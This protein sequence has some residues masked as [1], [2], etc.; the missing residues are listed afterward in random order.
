M[1]MAAIWEAVEENR[2]SRKG[3]LAEV[4]G[5]VILFFLLIKRGA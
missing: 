2:Q 1:I 5:M 4:V 3:I